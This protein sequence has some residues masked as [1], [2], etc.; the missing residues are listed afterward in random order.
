MSDYDEDIVLLD[1]PVVYL[2]PDE[3]V[4]DELGFDDETA[5]YVLAR[6][7]DD[8]DDVV[9]EELELYDVEE[10]AHRDRDVA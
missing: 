2:E 1:R 8:P 5:E 10:L 4:D 3:L 9:V 6:V 7:D